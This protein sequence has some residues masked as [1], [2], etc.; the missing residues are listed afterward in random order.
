QILIFVALAMGGFAI[1]TTE[2]ASMSLLPFVQHTVAVGEARVNYIISAYA[3]GVVY[4]APIIT[5]VAAGL[6]RKALLVSLMGVFALGN[7]LSALA[8]SFNWLILFRFISGLP[9]GAYFGLAS[10]VA[11]S[12][13]KPNRRTQAVGYVML[14]LTTA[15]IIGAPVATWLAAMSNWRVGYCAVTAL[16]LTACALI[17]MF[18]PRQKAR[19]S[20]RPSRELTALARP[21]VW[22][23]LS[24]GC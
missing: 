13:V 18:A 17:A 3:L 14:G 8:P 5:V 1:G 16:A 9:H 21:N 7:G 24:I 15:T 12:I 11:A 10:L 6:W 22:L 19:T 23:T 4:G 20:T 2:F